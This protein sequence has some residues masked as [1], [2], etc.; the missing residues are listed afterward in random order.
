MLMGT[1]EHRLDTK[2]RLVL[3]AR[4]REKLGDVVV[5][6]LG[7]EGCVSLYSEEEWKNFSGKIRSQ[8]FY[9]KPEARKFQRIMLGSAQEITIDGTG[10]VLLPGVLRE[11]AGL[12]LEVV[13]CGVNDHVEIWDRERW[14]AM[15]NAGLE[16]LSEMAEG[17][18]GF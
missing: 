18:E 6:A 7:M 15:W 17:M 8:P 12:T 9:S 14:A 11:H 1:Y 16:K 10:R 5:A 3:P 13:V 2:S 4:I